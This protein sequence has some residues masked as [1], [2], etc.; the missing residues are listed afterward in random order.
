MLYTGFLI[1]NWSECV[2]F[3]DEDKERLKKFVENNGHIIYRKCSQYLAS[4]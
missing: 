2:G 3:S 1:Y 4:V